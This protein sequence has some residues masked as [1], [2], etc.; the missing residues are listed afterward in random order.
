MADDE[1]SDGNELAPNGED[2]EEH[3]DADV[4]DEEI[5]DGDVVIDYDSEENEV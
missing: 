2:A 4:N 1:E 5:P 3:S